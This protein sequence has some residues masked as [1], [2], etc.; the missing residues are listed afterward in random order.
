MH[1]EGTDGRFPDQSPV[2]VRYPRSEQE[3]Q[4]DRERWP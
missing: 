2:E 4:G 3:E 1:D